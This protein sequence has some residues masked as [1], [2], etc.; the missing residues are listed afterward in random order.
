MVI[1]RNQTIV[2]DCFRNI[3]DLAADSA[4]QH[5]VGL[6]NFQAELPLYTPFSPIA[7][8]VHA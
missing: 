4:T 2:K 8:N 3:L 1:I 6:G 7:R 5:S